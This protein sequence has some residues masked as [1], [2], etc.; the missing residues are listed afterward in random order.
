M[1]VN[2]FSSFH[3]FVGGVAV[4]V[5]GNIN[6]IFPQAILDQIET[7][8]DL[9]CQPVTGNKNCFAIQRDSRYCRLD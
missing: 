9:F 2:L 5:L 6:T 4:G 1:S 7:C 3:C 8:D